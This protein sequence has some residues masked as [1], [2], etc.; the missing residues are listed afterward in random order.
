MPSIKNFNFFQRS[1]DVLKC[2][3]RPAA[4]V[5]FIILKFFGFNF[6]AAVN[7]F[8]KCAASGS[9]TILAKDM[10]MESN[11]LSKCPRLQ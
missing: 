9:T 1:D 3:P 7:V 6:D 4:T 2:A 11:S 5:R 10:R 8:K